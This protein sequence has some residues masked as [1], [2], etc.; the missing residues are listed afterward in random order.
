M[1]FYYSV[2]ELLP[3]IDKV[4]CSMTHL[5]IGKDKTLSKTKLTVSG[6]RGSANM[7]RLRADMIS[8][9][10]TVEEATR[11]AVTL[12]WPCLWTL[13]GGSRNLWE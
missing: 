2:F 7:V 6:S 4:G 5:D 9:K 8:Q 10:L 1:K 13:G 12:P 11:M 3:T